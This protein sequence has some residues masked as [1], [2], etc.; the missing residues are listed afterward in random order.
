MEIGESTIETAQREI[1]EETGLEIGTLSLF[2]VYSGAEFF[3]EYPNGDQVFSVSVVYFTHDVHG[4][5][6]PDGQEGLELGYF[7]LED[8]PLKLTP[9]ARTIVESFWR[10]NGIA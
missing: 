9:Q 5:L 7:S 4:D 2:D 1:R 6:K 3:N 8:L 10:K